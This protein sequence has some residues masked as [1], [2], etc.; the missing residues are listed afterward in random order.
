MAVF[1]PY[2][3]LRAKYPHA[4]VKPGDTIPVKGFEVN[5]VAAAGDS[6][7]GPLPGAA[8]PNPLCATS[9]ALPP[10]PGENARSIGMIMA[11]GNLR[12]S[13]LGD[14]SWN[15]E[16]DLA[17]PVNKLGTV[18]IY[19]TTHHGTATSGSPQMVDALH[20]ASPS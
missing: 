19:M 3:A 6:I 10:G 12:I 9:Q 16:Y 5:T 15:K 2:A 13:D 17:C 20:P 7:S 14:L 11:L 8:Q 4:T 18:D 1:E